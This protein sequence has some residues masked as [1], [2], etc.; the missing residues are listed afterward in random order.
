MDYPADL[1]IWIKR[2][3]MPFEKQLQCIL[4]IHRNPDARPTRTFPTKSAGWT[5]SLL[6]DD[7]WILDA[8][9]DVV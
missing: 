7:L 1:S 3:T 6:V 9:L 5:S 4:Q 2:S 8:Y